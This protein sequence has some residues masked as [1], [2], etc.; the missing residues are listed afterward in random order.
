MRWRNGKDST[1]GK[2]RGRHIRIIPHSIEPLGACARTGGLRYSDTSAELVVMTRFLFGGLEVMQ[3][4][5][6]AIIHD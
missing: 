5:R 2:W 4:R 6:I 3:S 1:F